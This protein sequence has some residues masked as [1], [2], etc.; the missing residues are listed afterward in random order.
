VKLKALETLDY[1][2]LL[3]KDIQKNQDYYL[4]LIQEFRDSDL[5]PKYYL[6]FENKIRE[7]NSKSI[8]AKYNTSL[9][10][11]MVCLFS[12]G[13]FGIVVFKR[14]NKRVGRKMNFLSSRERKVILLALEG[15]SNK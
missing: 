5:D 3:E 14:K 12:M 4:T 11:N 10:F 13:V 1:K 6:Y 15:K 7:I 2:G 8:S 9:F